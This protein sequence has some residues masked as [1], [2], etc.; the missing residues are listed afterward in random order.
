[1]RWDSVAGQPYET[2]NERFFVR[3]HTATPTIDSST[4]QRSLRSGER[5]RCLDRYRKRSRRPSITFA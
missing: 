3:N 5:A 4:W 2:A 1:M